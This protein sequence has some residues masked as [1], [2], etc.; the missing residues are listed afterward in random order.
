MIT[1]D[2][3]KEAVAKHFRISVNEIDANLKSHKRTNVYPRMV[4][5]YMCRK[6]TGQSDSYISEIFGYTGKSRH[7]IVYHFQKQVNN[8]YD[9]NAD[10]R[11]LIH[12]ITSDLEFIKNNYRAS[13]DDG[14]FPNHHIPPRHMKKKNVSIR[15]LAYENNRHTIAYYNFEE[16]EWKFEDRF[17]KFRFSNFQWTYMPTPAVGTNVAKV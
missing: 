15:V 10:F 4:A 12:K 5:I 1:I 6:Y 3:V 2:V 17:V 13:V 7:S 14:F 9:T 8:Q 16:M 11:V